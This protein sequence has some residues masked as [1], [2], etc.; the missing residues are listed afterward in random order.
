VRL[1]NNPSQVSIVMRVSTPPPTRI[2]V[3]CKGGSHRFALWR[4]QA[5]LITVSNRSLLKKGKWQ[6][7]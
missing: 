7:L 1:Q 3:S 6:L 5:A 4:R 2:R